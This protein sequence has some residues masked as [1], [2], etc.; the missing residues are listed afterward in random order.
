MSDFADIQGASDRKNVCDAACAAANDPDFIAAQEAARQTAIQNHFKNVISSWCNENS[1][2]SS[3]AMQ[4]N[5]RLAINDLIT[6]SVLDSWESQ[7]TGKG[8]VITRDGSYFT[9]ALPVAP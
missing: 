1:E 5:L 2:S 7:L 4:D 9:I 6:S 8:Y 3:A